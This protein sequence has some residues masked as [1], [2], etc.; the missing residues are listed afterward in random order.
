MIAIFQRREELMA[1]L[2]ARPLSERAL[3][4]VAVMH[5]ALGCLVTQSK[6]KTTY[7]AV[8]LVATLRS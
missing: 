2:A 1:L 4:A 7:K 5:Y 8:V 3:L 6:I